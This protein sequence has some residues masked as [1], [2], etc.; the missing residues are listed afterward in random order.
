MF[1][2]DAS[3]D[4]GA[5]RWKHEDVNHALWTKMAHVPVTCAQFVDAED[6][7]V[8]RPSPNN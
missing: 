3:A 1:V 6:G 5:C 7:S 8:V 2:E 4:G